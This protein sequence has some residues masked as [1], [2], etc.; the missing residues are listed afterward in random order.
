MV[1]S[2]LVKELLA[3]GATV[4][5]LVHDEEPGSEL[6]R[7][8][9]LGRVSIVRGG[10][11]DYAT[12]E[13]AVN[14][15]AVDTV[16][17]LGAQTLV[18]T[19]YRSPLATFEANIRGSYHLLEACRVH[20]GLVKRVVVASSDKAYGE[21]AQLPYTEEAPLIARHPYDVSKSCTDLLAQTYHHT[22]G[23]PVTISRC[24]NIYGGGDLNWSRVVPGTI[25]SVLRGE[26]P[27]I[28][29]DGRFV[30]DYLY[31]RDAVS[32]YLRLAEEAATP[33]LSGQPFNFSTETPIT[34]LEVVREIQ[35]LTGTTHLE[36]VI[37]N[38]ARAEIHSQHLS[39]TRARETLGWTAAY[40]LKEGLRETLFWYAGYLG[41]TA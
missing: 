35:E 4:V 13:R 36:P 12:V 2:W 17:H 19:A 26:R 5:A 18:G 21:H 16:F 41:V 27:I 40:S 32:A 24:G 39:A 6:A 1:G 37:L 33:G 10:L 14:G 15:F 11:E 34:V 8:G 22:Y 25:R 38:E 31:V 30:R 7:S 29:S 28:R 9:D 3:K 20:S 23:V